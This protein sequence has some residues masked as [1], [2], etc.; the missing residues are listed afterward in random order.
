MK[1]ENPVYTIVR[2]E[3]PDF[4]CEGRG[5]NELITDKIF[6]KDED[7]AISVVDVEEKLVWQR[8]LDEGM[9][10]SLDVKGKLFAQLETKRLIL[11]PWR[12][13]DAEDLYA[14]ASNTKVGPMAGWKPHDNIEESKRILEMF[15]DDG[16]V[17]AIEWKENHKVIGSI[18]LHQSKKADIEYD[19]ELGYVLSEAYWGQGIISEAAERIKQFA[20]EDLKISRLLVAHFDFNHQS[21][22]VIEKLGFSYLTHVCNTRKRYDG[23]ALEEEVYL[24]TKD[25]FLKQIETRNC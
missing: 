12:M 3:E 19:R 13:D 4:G 20:F 6:L 11:R 23:V 2:I 14:Y 9:Q 1:K 25:D 7:G 5:E 15:V 10:V 22:R 18:G 24:M 16:D 21:K 8:G 17:W